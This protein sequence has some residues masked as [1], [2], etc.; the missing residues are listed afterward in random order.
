MSLASFSTSSNIFFLADAGIGTKDFFNWLSNFCLIESISA[1]V[2]VSF[3]FCIES[4][5][6]TSVISA[7]LSL[8][9]SSYLSIDLDKPTIKKKRMETV[10]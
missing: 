2:G 5:L 1:S 7:T 3:F 4:F 9:N 8:A 6:T 10:K